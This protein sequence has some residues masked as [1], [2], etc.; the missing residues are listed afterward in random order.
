MAESV[1][2][3]R[4]QNHLLIWALLLGLLFNYLFS[5]KQVGL[6]CPVF[7]IV[8][9]L[10]F[11]INMKG[12]V[13]WRERAASCL[14]LIPV[15]ALAITYAL[16]S[17]NFF[18]L[19]N[20]LV[21]PALIVV[22]TNL[23]YEGTA[24]KWDTAGALIGSFFYRVGLTLAGFFVP[25]SVIKRS[26][27]QRGEKERYSVLKKV[28]VGVIISLPFMLLVIYLL[29]SADQIFAYYLKQ[30]AYI[31]IDIGLGD[32]LLVLAV[33]FLSFGYILGFWNQKERADR[34]QENQPEEEARHPDNPAGAVNVTTDVVKKWDPVTVLTF[35]T[36]LNIVYIAFAVIQFS[37]LFGVSSLALPEGFTYAEYARRGFFELTVISIL[38][39]S[40]VLIVIGAACK[41]NRLALGAIQGLLMLMVISTAVMLISAHLRLSLYE[42]VFGFTFLRVLAHVFMAYI[43]ALLVILLVK[44]IRYYTRLNQAFLL[45]SLI[46]YLAVNYANFDSFIARKNIDRYFDSGKLDQGY[47]L[48][49]SNNAAP[50]MIRLLE[51]D[52]QEITA[53]VRAALDWRKK[54]LPQQWQSFNYADHLLRKL[55]D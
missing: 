22:H 38:N 8:F 45:I 18:W 6:S 24:G 5:G 4:Q 21:L 12:I 25:F 7:T 26:L 23:C 34:L 29:A 27:R 32:V 47:L 48:S 9:Y 43:I 53:G 54:E 36:L 44:I 10:F 37:Y 31:N 1:N 51:V 50:Q 16:F 42:Q 46:F 13:Q 35:L 30:I 3:N 41:K 55:A 40:I 17:P 52:D 39:V 14:L 19:I 11:F 20:F 33:A 15:L 28:L 2:L 49:L